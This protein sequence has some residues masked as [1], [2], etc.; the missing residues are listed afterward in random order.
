MGRVA[1]LIIA[2]FAYKFRLPHLRRAVFEAALVTGML[3]LVIIGASFPTYVV[4]SGG[5]GKRLAE[6]VVD[7]GMSPVGFIIILNILYL[8][9]GCIMD[10]MTILL[11]TLP[12]FVP[13]VT[14]LG[15]DM[16]WFGILVV[17]NLQIGLITPPLGLD[18][19]IMRNTF[20]IPTGELLRGVF[21]FLINLLVFLAL[22]VAFPEITLWLVNLM[23]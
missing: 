19:Y 16:V 23:E 10:T 8:F 1:S 21:P 22:L 7:I 14:A 15:F 6:V 13:A 20:G 3:I 17:V 9:L 11:L 12:I 5:L 4:G 18:L 2:V